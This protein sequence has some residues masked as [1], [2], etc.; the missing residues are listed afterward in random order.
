MALTATANIQVKLDIVNVLKI[1]NCISF[2]SS[3]NRTNLTYAVLN[4]DP[5]KIDDEIVSF[6]GKKYQG[7]CGIIYCTSR[8]KCEETAAKLK[9]KGLK[10]DFYHAGLDTDDRVR[11]Q[12]AWAANEINIIVATIAFGMGIDKPDVRFVIHYSLPQSLEGYYQETGRAGRDGNPSDCLL[13][14]SYRDKHSIENMIDKGEGDRDQK[15]RQRSNLRSM[16]AY[17]EN[18]IECRRHLILSV[19]FSLI[20]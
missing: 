6:I 9:R 20:I 13:Y 2:V 17:C 3:F 18:Q 7:A 10:I 4:K 12:N 16:I 14:Y 11:V 15:E 1:Q 5:K 8:A 19:I